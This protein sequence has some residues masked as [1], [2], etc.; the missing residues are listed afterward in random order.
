MK[1]VTKILFFISFL[2]LLFSL[3]TVAQERLR[4]SLLTCTPGAELNEVFG[5]SALRVIDSNSVTDHVY[6]YGTFNFED[7]DF[8]LKFIKGKLRYFV[9]IENCSDF[10]FYYHALKRGITEQVLEFSDKEKVTIKKLLQ[11]N[12]K[13]ENKYY[14]YEFF[15]DNCTTRLRDII[16][17]NHSPTPIMPAVMPVTFTYRNAIHQ[18]LDNG[19][20]PWSKLGIDILLGARTDAVMTSDQQGF[21]PDNLMKAL[22]VTKNTLMVSSPKQLFELEKAEPK[23]VVF[24]PMVFSISMLLVFMIFHFTQKNGS[25]II[26]RAL[27]RILFLLVGLLGILLIFMW[28]GTD[29]IMTKNNYNLLWAS[30]MFVVYVFVLNSK[31]TLVKRFSLLMAIFLALLICLWTF[32]PEQLN[33]ALI[34][35]VG[36]LCW[37]LFSHSRSMD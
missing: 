19:N 30:P 5:H 2:L 23:K 25:K 8:Y 37:R 34:P 35:I 29:H 21:L 1:S 22:D 16:K 26:L 28:F 27:D 33:V 4:I 36:L 3:N 24:T 18:Y 10:V 17:N 20:M 15:N 12:I 13:E 9:E 11:E 14:Q 7:K 32:L 6:N 31:S